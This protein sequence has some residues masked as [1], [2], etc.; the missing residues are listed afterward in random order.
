MYYGTNEGR[1]VSR[2]AKSICRC[3]FPPWCAEKFFL[4]NCG[5]RRHEFRFR[6]GGSICR[7][8]F[9]D[10]GAG[11]ALRA[12]SPAVFTRISGEGIFVLF[13]PEI[14]SLAG[15]AR[16]QSNHSFWARMRSHL[17]LAP[18]FAFHIPKR[19]FCFLKINLSL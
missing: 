10:C 6:P 4:G 9:G 7:D 16:K 1:A 17:S 11:I 12:T 18:C 3:G 15:V 8:A 14:Y 5:R 19:G 2:C 13:A